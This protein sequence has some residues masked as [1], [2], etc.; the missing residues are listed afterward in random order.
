MQF[1]ARNR[2]LSGKNSTK[3]QMDETQCLCDENECP[4]CLESIHELTE[5]TRCCNQRIHSKC[6]QS[7]IDFNSARHESTRCPLCRE[8]VHDYISIDIR[9]EETESGTPKIL[10][11]LLCCLGAFEITGIMLYKYLL[12]KHIIS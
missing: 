4:I 2:N 12:S 1:S 10:P 5:T 6:M 11:L 7:L 9:E 8:L 3:T